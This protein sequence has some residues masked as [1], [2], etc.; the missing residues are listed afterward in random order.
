M[1]EFRRNRAGNW[2]KPLTATR[3]IDPIGAPVRPAARE[4]GPVPDIAPLGTESVSAAGPTEPELA[5]PG[6]G[7]TE[8]SHVR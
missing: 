2:P 1:V 5:K 4:L 8:P 6:P 3:E 7:A